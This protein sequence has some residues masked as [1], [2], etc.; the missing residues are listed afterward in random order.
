MAEEGLLPTRHVLLGPAANDC[1]QSDV[2]TQIWPHSSNSLYV[3]ALQPL[4]IARIVEED[5][6]VLCFADSQAPCPLVNSRWLRPGV[7]P[8]PFLQLLFFSFAKI[9]IT[10]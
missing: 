4:S 9:E 2:V 3:C 8:A 1:V 5:A 6:V 10:S 7:T